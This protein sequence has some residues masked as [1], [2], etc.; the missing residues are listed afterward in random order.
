ML[1]TC[2]WEALS[3]GTFRPFSTL[4]RRL[5]SATWLSLCKMIDFGNPSKRKIISLP[6][7]HNIETPRYVSKS[8]FSSI[9]P[10]DVCLVTPRLRVRWSRQ[11]P[12]DPKPYDL[13]MLLSW[14]ELVPLK[15]DLKTLKER[16]FLRWVSW[17]SESDGFPR[18]LLLT[19]TLGLH[20]FP[21]PK[22]LPLVLLHFS[23]GAFENNARFDESECKWPVDAPALYRKK[24]WPLQSSIACG[25]L[26]GVIIH[27]LVGFLL[28]FL[29][30]LHPKALRGW[31]CS[32]ALWAGLRLSLGAATMHRFSGQDVWNLVSQVSSKLGC[33]QL[34]SL[35]SLEWSTQDWWYTYVDDF[36]ITGISRAAAVVSLEANH[37][38]LVQ[39]VDLGFAVSVLQESSTWSLRAVSA[40]IEV[41]DRQIHMIQ[42]ATPTVGEERK[43][44]KLDM[45]RRWQCCEWC[46]SVTVNSSGFFYSWC[47]ISDSWTGDWRACLAHQGPVVTRHAKR[48][49]FEK[50]IHGPHSLL[51]F[52]HLFS[53]CLPLKLKV[54]IEIW[55]DQRQNP[56]VHSSM[57]NRRRFH[58]GRSWLAIDGQAWG[59]AD[60]TTMFSSPTCGEPWLCGHFAGASCGVVFC[61]DIVL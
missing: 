59:P 57:K 51:Y 15:C 61:F 6:Q 1:R 8:K 28:G 27:S 21:L 46:E 25:L 26:W 13:E 12:S 35:V 45:V 10:R 56:T 14:L 49:L 42:N 60:P 47:E 36:V 23:L 2:D 43:S 48:I 18:C 55:G 39:V 11:D 50:L 7:P 52:F 3:Q 9:V 40:D 4:C 32:G 20:T 22:Q 41:Q 37:Q 19:W 34:T 30:P 53:R 24:G 33:H 5:W 17:V 38:V 31:S 16:R 29:V 54:Q 58:S 44:G